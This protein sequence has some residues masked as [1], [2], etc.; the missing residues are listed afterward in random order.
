[1]IWRYK[2]F[3]IDLLTKDGTP[4]LSEVCPNAQRRLEVVALECKAFVYPYLSGLGSF[5]ISKPS[6]I[7]IYQYDKRDLTHHR[8]ADGL[9][10]IFYEDIRTVA[11]LGFSEVFVKNAELDML[12][13]MFLHEVAHLKHIKHNFDYV[14]H[15]NHLVHCFNRLHGTAI[16]N[17]LDYGGWYTCKNGHYTY[18]ADSRSVCTA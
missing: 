2:D 1:M 10:T 16:V 6:L 8:N 5:N 3:A 11:A 15:L 12:R 4:P 7:Y 14:L 13:L 17:N 9:C 18:R